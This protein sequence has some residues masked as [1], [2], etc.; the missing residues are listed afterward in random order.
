MHESA[1]NSAVLLLVGSMAIGL[2]I[3]TQGYQD[4]AAFTSAPFKGVLC[5]FLLDMGLV[6]AKRLESL[7]QAGPVTVGF[8]VLSPPV[9]ATLGI[10]AAYVLGLGPGDALLLAVLAGSASYI[11]VPAALRMALPEANPS[12]YVPMSLGLTFPFNVVLG[13]PLYWAMVQWMW[14]G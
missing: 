10:G 7:K 4:V 9:H 13:I 3:G 2:L 6:A 12:L 11:A 8:A 1:F 14:A 5:L